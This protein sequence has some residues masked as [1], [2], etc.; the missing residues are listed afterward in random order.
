RHEMGG[1]H[2]L[3]PRSA[4]SLA[5]ILPF[6][7]ATGLRGQASVPETPSYGESVDVTLVTTSIYVVDGDGNPITDLRP[8]EVQVRVGGKLL[9]LASFE[10]GVAATEPASAPAAA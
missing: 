10:R 1:V 2:P 6:A 9:P 4:A 7:L 3:L 8:E 5:V